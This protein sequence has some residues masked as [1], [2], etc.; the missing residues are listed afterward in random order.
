M[1]LK[2]FRAKL[3]PVKKCRKEGLFLE[4]NLRSKKWLISWSYNPHRTFLSHLLNSIGKNL[5]LLSGNYENVFLMGDFN[6][7][8]ENI[9]LKISVIYTTLKI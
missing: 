6:A 9:N 2:T 4:L 5:N 7:D 8:M 1:S 3:I